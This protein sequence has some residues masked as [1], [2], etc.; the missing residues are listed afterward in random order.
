MKQRKS[1]YSYR[2]RFNNNNVTDTQYGLQYSHDDNVVAWINGNTNFN[3]N[4]HY[5]D[6]YPT[7]NE[8]NTKGE[9]HA[10]EKNHND[11]S[12]VVSENNNMEGRQQPTQTMKVLHDENSVIMI[13][14]NSSQEL[15]VHFM[16][17]QNASAHNN[18]TINN[19]RMQVFI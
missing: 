14:D 17:H 3:K 13:D 7:R 9:Q 16:F 2:D 4:E 10:Q 18:N 1:G 5:V 8:N 11:E 6:Q 19:K 12:T 15:A